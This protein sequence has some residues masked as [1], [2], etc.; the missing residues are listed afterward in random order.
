MWGQRSGQLIGYYIE[1][2][3]IS[4]SQKRKWRC[5]MKTD[6]ICKNIHVSDDFKDVIEKKIDKLDKYFVGNTAANVVLSAS[7]TRQ[8]V[9]ATI[10]IKGSIFRAEQEANDLGEGIDKVVEKLSS[11]MSKYKTKLHKKHKDNHEQEI[12]FGEFPENNEEEEEI[13]IIKTKNFVLHPMNVEEAIMQMELLD[14]EF[15]V[16]LDGNTGKINVVYKRKNNGYGLIDP[17]YR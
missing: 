3:T 10:R 7:G 8:K 12:M 14:H 4:K 17:D 13:E 6:I 2:K 5:M 9:E 1:D 16:F 15:F 11:Q